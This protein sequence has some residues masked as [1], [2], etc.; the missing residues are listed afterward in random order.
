[1]KPILIP[2]SF[3][4]I[5][6]FGYWFQSCFVE[7]QRFRYRFYYWFLRSNT[8]SS[9]RSG[10]PTI[11]ISIPVSVMEI[12]RFQLWILVS[13]NKKSHSLTKREVYQDSEF[14]CQ[15]L[16]LNSL[17]Y[18]GNTYKMLLVVSQIHYY[19]HLL[20]L[21]LIVF[22]LWWL[23]HIILIRNITKNAVVCS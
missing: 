9:F 21:L 10:N 12:E 11:P 19:W 16:L 1:M 20:I 17:L 6:C 13:N 3:L 15:E 8:K 14:W 18:T 5:H 23:L 22:V 4:E 2:V 7:I